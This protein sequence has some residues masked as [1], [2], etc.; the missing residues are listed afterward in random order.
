MLSIGWIVAS[1]L[2]G[3]TGAAEGVDAGEAYAAGTA[4]FERLD[5]PCAIELLGAASREGAGLDPQLQVEVFRKLAES[6]LALNQ[7]GD[8]VDCFSRL[9]KLAPAYRIDAAGVSPKILDALEEARARLERNSPLPGPP[10]AVAPPSKGMELS[11]TGGVELLVGRDEDLL[12]TGG[13]FEL[14]FSKDLGGVWRWIAAVR[15]G[16]HGLGGSASTLFLLGGWTGIGAAVRLGPIRLGAG[17]GLGAA[18]FGVLA[19]EGK[20]GLL[21]PLIATIDTP[22]GE[23]WIVG[24]S[25]SPGWVVSFDP[26]AAASFTVIGGL[27]LGMRF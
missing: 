7:R 26:D 23:G 14:A 16:F 13:S 27:H 8:A 20:A 22:I 9:L 21:V 11:L 18:T 19:K 5:Y 12:E 3:V 24:L 6:H 25:V 10:A 1:I 4:C 15:Y 2:A 17:A